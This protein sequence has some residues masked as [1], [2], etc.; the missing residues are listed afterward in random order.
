MKRFSRHM[1]RL[2]GCKRSGFS[3]F[4][5]FVSENVKRNEFRVK[6]TIHRK[7][8][9]FQ[10]SS[11]SLHGFRNDSVALRSSDGRA[12]SRGKAGKPS[13]EKKSTVFRSNFRP[14]AAS[15]TFIPC[16]SVKRFRFL[17]RRRRAGQE[18][19]RCRTPT[20]PER[21]LF[22]FRR[23]EPS[24]RLG[25]V[26]LP[27]ELPTFPESWR[28]A[29]SEPVVRKFPRHLTVGWR[30]DRSPQGR[31][32]CVRG[33][34]PNHGRKRREPASRFPPSCRSDADRR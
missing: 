18:R 31:V 25:V 7:T 2:L 15:G 8:R 29:S 27:C 12:Q 4:E 13:C 16:G 23:V 30:P 5:I 6:R 19:L 20:R 9:F 26:G 34:V 24:S 1:Q 3:V 21:R 22:P 17:S 11:E 14:P 28:S 33:C 10:D 32:R